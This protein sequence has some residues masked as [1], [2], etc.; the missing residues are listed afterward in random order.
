[1]KLTKQ[2]IMQFLWICI[3]LFVQFSGNAQVTF[4]DS[5]FSANNYL[6]TFVGWEGVGLCSFLLISFWWDRV[7]KDGVPMNANAG[8]KA[9]V[10]NRIGDFGVILAIV[11]RAASPE[12]RS[13]ALG[14][15]TAAEL[16]RRRV[17]FP[18]GL[19]LGWSERAFTIRFTGTAACKMYHQQKLIKRRQR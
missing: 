13:M 15:A 3:F 11:G 10:V 7:D 4:A 14:I 19:D 16:P 12:N 2:W 17:L 18:T 8:R 6:V 1:M 5:L 9:F